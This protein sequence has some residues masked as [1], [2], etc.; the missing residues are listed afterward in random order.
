MFW[1]VTLQQKVRIHPMK[2]ASD[3]TSTTIQSELR[4]AVEG[5]ITN[6]TGIILTVQ[7]IEGYGVG[8]VSQRTGFAIYDVKYRAIV[9]R[10][11]PNQVIDAFIINVNDQGIKAEA[12]PLELFIAKKCIKPDYVYDV[13]NTSFTNRNNSEVLMKGG[14]I[15]V[16]IINTKPHTDFTKLTATATMNGDGLGYISS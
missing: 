11:L 16:R 2:L 3:L 9:F 8:K 4:N 12:G 1:E 14:R 15:R 6:E 7:K 5:V 10:P 13:E